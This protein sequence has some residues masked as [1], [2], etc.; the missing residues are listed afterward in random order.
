M[1]KG[2]DLK[3]R[4]E[5]CFLEGNHLIVLIPGKLPLMRQQCA[6][7]VCVYHGDSSGYSPTSPHTV[8]RH[9]SSSQTCAIW[10]S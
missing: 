8:Q 9:R 4:E 5:N 7:V 6:H 10:G 3:K 1:T 2:H